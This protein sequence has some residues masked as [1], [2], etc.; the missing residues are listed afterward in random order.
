M[1]SFSRSFA[2][3]VLLSALPATAADRPE[4]KVLRQADVT[5]TRREALDAEVTAA[6]EDAIVRLTA[7]LR[8]G[9]GDDDTRAE[10]VMRLAELHAE[11]ARALALEELSQHGEAFDRCFDTP[12]CAPEAL[13]ADHRASTAQLDRSTG[14]YRKLLGERPDFARA[15]EATYLLAQGLLMRADLVGDGAA[16]DEALRELTRLV[17]TWP[18]TEHTSDAFL[19]LGE[20]YFDR[21]DVLKALPAYQRAAA[22]ATFAQ[23]D[24]ARYKLAWCQYNV[25]E[26]AAGFATLRE[27]IL[28]PTPGTRVTLQEEAAKDLVRFAAEAGL[29]DEA[30]DVFERLG[31]PDLQRKTMVSLAAM[32]VEQGRW[33]R[34]ELLYKRVVAANPEAPDAPGLELEAYRALLRRSSSADGVAALQTLRLRYGRQ[35]AWALANSG[36]TAARAEADRLVATELRRFGTE[37]HTR[38]RDKADLGLADTLY[39]AFL[40]DHPTAPEAIEVRYQHAE[41]LYKLGRHDAAYD[42][43]MAVVKADPS[44]SRA[45]FCAESAVFAAQEVAVPARRAQ[46]ATPAAGLLPA[47]RRWLDALD[48]YVRLFPDDSKRVQ[49]MYY[50]AGYL[51]HQAG[52]TRSAAER[53]RTVIA[54]NP[55][56]RDAEQAAGLI[57]DG[58]AQARD[59]ET[60]R[61]TALAFST[62]AGLGTAAFR[63]EARVTAGDA[64]LEG[65]EEVRR[66]SGDDRAAIAAL[67]RFDAEFPDS[68]RAAV[69]LHNRASFAEGLG[70]YPEVVAAGEALVARY[71]RDKY[72]EAMIGR[73]GFAY[74]SLA[75]FSAAADWYERLAASDRPEAAD[76]LYSA[77]VFRT[78]LGQPARA[79]ADYETL[80]RRWPSRPDAVGVRFEVARLLEAQGDAAGAARAWML[81]V[82]AGTPDE[83]MTARLRY[84]RL[85]PA[86]ARAAEAPAW[87]R[88]SLTAY[89][90][91]A[92]MGTGG[93]GAADAAA[94]MAFSLAEADFGAALALRMDGPGATK[95]TPRKADALLQAQF[96]QKLRAVQVVEA[97]YS[98]V[99][100][101]GSTP[102]AIESLVRMG[103][104]YEDLSA[105]ILASW[106][107]AHLTPD[108][109]EIYRMRLEDL[110]WAPRE[111][112]ATFYE[113]AATRAAS[114]TF[115]SEATVY[116]ASRLRALGRPDAPVPVE[117]LPRAEFFANAASRAGIARE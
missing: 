88:E 103:R 95:L 36:D 100:G 116:A 1:A 105:A 21:G 92:A 4:R 3:V 14:L 80:S 72:A 47:E 71:P 87:W 84:G 13:K 86:L 43:Y 56:T 67:R 104:A 30:G 64:T 82:G 23:R 15:D 48:Q 73:V 46:G 33:E 19:L 9:V 41:L 50:R 66:A 32:Y 115:R 29:E 16:R 85:L 49:A 40:E 53:F 24:F 57:L 31:R 63:A 74:E 117:T 25:G 12:G 2:L 17:R 62:E 52:D 38:K 39:T 98:H 28:A 83:Q 77:A 93:A 11:S 79:L 107:P 20:L 70:L 113:A 45:R 106:V 58:L 78:A 55:G 99:V 60:L 110:A 22:D 97:T 81:L 27:V 26:F 35:G 114:L 91:I 96:T 54:L 18:S 69:A 109:Q 51:H 10:M 101:L 89:A 6:R 111:R 94:E 68:P 59:W 8:S 112:A 34:A 102:W 5:E 7:L 44:G 65:I 90:R 75:H 37:L 61:V 76:A 108:Q 42:A